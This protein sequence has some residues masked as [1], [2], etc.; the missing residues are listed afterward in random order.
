MFP[1]FCDCVLLTKLALFPIARDT[2]S[3]VRC[4]ARSDTILSLGPL[5]AGV[6]DLRE[7]VPGHARCVVLSD[8]GAG[9]LHRPQLEAALR[10]A[11]R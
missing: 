3:G 11:I 6:V 7:G 4:P 10:D 5:A 9:D 2:V 1:E 8:L